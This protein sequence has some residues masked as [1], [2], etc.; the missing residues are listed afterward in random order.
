MNE[1]RVTVRELAAHLLYLIENGDGDKVV[2][3]SVLYD[4]CEH[5]QY[6]NNVHN[7]DGIDWITIAGGEHD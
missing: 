7:F 1:K 5:I 6:M 2:K 3:V 4:N